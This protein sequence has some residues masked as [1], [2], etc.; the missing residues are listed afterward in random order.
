MSYNFVH[1]YKGYTGRDLQ[2]KL[3]KTAADSY[4]RT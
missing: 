2:E 1:N 4:H 3:V